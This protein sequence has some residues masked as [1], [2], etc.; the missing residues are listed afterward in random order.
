MGDYDR[1]S[2]SLNP[3]LGSL[4]ICQEVCEL[5]KL[6]IEKGKETPGGFLMRSGRAIPLGD[7]PV[8]VFAMTGHRNDFGWQE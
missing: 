2:I 6:A 5:S 8:N 1:A 3:S 7:L 4:L